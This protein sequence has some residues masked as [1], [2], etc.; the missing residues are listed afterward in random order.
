MMSAPVLA[1]RDRQTAP[2]GPALR[3]SA[4]VAP[5]HVLRFESLFDAGRAYS[6]P[7]DAQGRVSLDGLSERA[8]NNYLFA[9]ACVGREFAHPCVQAALH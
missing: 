7:C 1:P 9:R 2:A 6:F 8:R 5:Q 3:P 4:A